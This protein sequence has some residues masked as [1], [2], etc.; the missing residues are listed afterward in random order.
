MPGMTMASIIAISK[1]HGRMYV[2]VPSISPTK[3]ELVAGACSTQALI[4]MAAQ[5]LVQCALQSPLNGWRSVNKLIE[6]TIVIDR[7]LM[8]N[9]CHVR[10]YEFPQKHETTQDLCLLIFLIHPKQ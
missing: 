1:P 2:K 7:S 5:L 3:S 4:P 6:S 10:Y 8:S 9:L